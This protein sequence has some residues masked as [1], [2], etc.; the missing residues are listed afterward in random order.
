MTH[1][2]D[3]LNTE[4]WSA[5]PFTPGLPE[6]QELTFCYIYHVPDTMPSASYALYYLIFTGSLGSQCWTEELRH[7]EGTKHAQANRTNMAELGF[8]PR[9]SEAAANIPNQDHTSTC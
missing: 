4:I 7:R 8:E 3:L 2:R 5:F 6:S 1:L 9:Y